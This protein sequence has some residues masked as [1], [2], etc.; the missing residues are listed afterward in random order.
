ML[1]RNAQDPMA[2]FQVRHK[3]D[4]LDTIASSHETMDDAQ[5]ALKDMSYPGKWG[6][7]YIVDNSKDVAA[8]AVN[9]DAVKKLQEQIAYEDL[10]QSLLAK[11]RQNQVDELAISGMTAKSG[12]SLPPPPAE[13]VKADK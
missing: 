4:A 6:R 1:A 11:Q 3:F 9:E 10:R 13:M 8:S 2:R 5:E 12:T 7:L